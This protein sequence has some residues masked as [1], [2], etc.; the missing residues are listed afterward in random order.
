MPIG[1]TCEDGKNSIALEA[2]RPGIDPRGQ[3]RH[4]RPMAHD[5]IREKL[6]RAIYREFLLEEGLLVEV[7]LE[8][9]P[10][11]LAALLGRGE[12]EVLTRLTASPWLE[13]AELADLRS[14]LVIRDMSLVSRTAAA[15]SVELKGVGVSYDD[16]CR[17]ALCYAVIGS[18]G[19]AFSA[20]RAAASK[21]DRWARHH[22]LY[23]LLLGLEQN[24]ERACWEL[25]KAL[26]AE[27]YEEGRIRIRRVL[28]LLEGCGG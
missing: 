14:L 3:A 12:H 18:H 28:D 2:A 16:C 17:M 9:V 20:L 25:G 27:P 15:V 23:G 10:A 21:N 24:H 22:Y 11:R 1:L 8:D 7:G 26:Q 6:Q 19:H 4:H 13:A 5:E